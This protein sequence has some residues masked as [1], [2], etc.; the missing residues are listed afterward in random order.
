M[1]RCGDFGLCARREKNAAM[2]KQVTDKTRTT[3]NAILIPDGLFHF[4]TSRSSAAPAG[5]KLAASEATA[6]I[7]VAPVC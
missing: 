6:A 5:D 7:A 1:S 3:P 4:C 2:R